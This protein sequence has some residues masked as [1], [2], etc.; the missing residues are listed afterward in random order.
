MSEV[1]ALLSRD[2]DLGIASTV[3]GRDCRVA[4]FI[5]A[6]SNLLEGMNRRSDTL[7]SKSC[8]FYQYRTNGFRVMKN[9]VSNRAF[10]EHVYF[11]RV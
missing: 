4:N 11:A 7:S 9:N 3:F 6:L 8:K 2:K 10:R 5:Y 1:L